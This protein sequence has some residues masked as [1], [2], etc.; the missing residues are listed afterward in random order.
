MMKTEFVANATSKSGL[1]SRI[2][3][4]WQCFVSVF[5]KGNWRPACCRKLCFFFSSFSMLQKWRSLIPRFC[6]SWW[7][8]RSHSRFFSKS[9]TFSKKYLCQCCWAF[10]F[11]KMAKT[12]QNKIRW[13][14][15]V[16]SYFTL[17]YLPF[18]FFI[19]NICSSVIK[20]GRFTSYV[21]HAWSNAALPV[22]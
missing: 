19:C 1:T 21:S 14:K 4:T 3:L 6:H 17:F 5:H 7:Q 18:W 22:S 8:N 10:S 2:S 13:Q 9:G 11:T 12:R 16:T 15:P 20:S